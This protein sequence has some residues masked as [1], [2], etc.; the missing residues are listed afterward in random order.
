MGGL[1][2]S[3]AGMAGGTPSTMGPVGWFCFAS[4]RSH[5]NIYVIDPTYTSRY[6]LN[7]LLT[8]TVMEAS[9]TLVQSIT[10]RSH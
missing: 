5:R 1:A 2:G 10:L 6:I 8:S 7:R 9:A 4:Y 3:F